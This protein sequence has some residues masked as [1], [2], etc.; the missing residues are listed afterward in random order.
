[1]IGQLGFRD[2]IRQTDDGVRKIKLSIYFPEAITHPA[3]SSRSAS[4]APQLP[5]LA[6]DFTV[7]EQQEDEDSKAIQVFV[8]SDVLRAHNADILF[9]SNSMTLYDDDRTKL[10]IPLVRP[11][12][13]RTFKTLYTTS[14]PQNP[15]TKRDQR[16]GAEAKAEM[17]NG[18]G[19]LEAGGVDIAASGTASLGGEVTDQHTDTGTEA[20][21]SEK[22]PSKEALQENANFEQRPNL[23]RVSTGADGDLTTEQPPTSN[24][25]SRSGASPAIWS[26]WR[27][28]AD[29]SSSDWATS[30]RSSNSTY[31]RRDQGIKV[32]KPLRS[33]SRAFSSSSQTS[34]PATGTLQQSRFFDE[35]RRRVDNDGTETQLKRAASGEIKPGGNGKENPLASSS[36]KPRA[37]NPVGG[38]SAFAWLNSGGG[39]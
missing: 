17:T 2:Q 10:A 21:I 33:S 12:E 34:T 6:I 36:S 9:S 23:S 1:L 27:R 19:R 11:E 37:S 13:E 28:D 29:K 7:I 39:K 3:A 22:Y 4:P 16:R 30:T 25:M 8:G 38:A 35:G 15:V 24:T 20:E 31:Q 5:S 14:T 18:A 26:N 32:L